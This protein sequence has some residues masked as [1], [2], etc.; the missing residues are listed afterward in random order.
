MSLCSYTSNVRCQG[1]KAALVG[2]A[3]AY[4]LHVL[5][6]SLYITRLVTLFLRGIRLV[7]FHE[8]NIESLAVRLEWDCQNPDL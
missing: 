2:R 3:F 4:D 8:Q 1:R 6:G 5:N 7:I